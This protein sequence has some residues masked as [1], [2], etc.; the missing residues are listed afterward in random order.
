MAQATNSSSETFRLSL[1]VEPSLHRL[2][3]LAAAAHDQTI[4]QYV[5]EAIKERLVQDR[6]DDAGTTI[7]MAAA[8]P[9]LA[10]LWDNAKDAEY[11]RL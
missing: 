6:N 3:R 11:D 7:V 2:L 4:G 1:E 9:V 8:D 10:E 5:L